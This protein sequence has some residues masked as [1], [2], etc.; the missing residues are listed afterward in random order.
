MRKAQQSTN[1]HESAPISRMV[2]AT[3]TGITSQNDYDEA[4]SK[5]QLGVSRQSG[6]HQFSTVQ[7][8]KVPMPIATDLTSDYETE[9]SPLLDRRQARVL[10]HNQQKH[11]VISPPGIMSELTAS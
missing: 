10:K 3:G 2:R 5:S 9:R 8:Q 11:P 7:A 6:R 4:R 1:Q